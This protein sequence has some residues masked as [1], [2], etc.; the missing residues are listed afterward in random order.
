MYSEIL[1]WDLSKYNG[2]ADGSTDVDF[3]IGIAQGVQA[4]FYRGTIGTS[5]IDYKFYT[6][7]QKSMAR[8]LPFAPYHAFRPEA[9]GRAQGYA[10]AQLVMS[11]VGLTR[12]GNLSPVFDI[13]VDGGLPVAELSSKCQKMIEGYRAA[14][15][16]L[17]NGIQIEPMIYTS[18]GWWNDHM[19]KSAWASVYR[20]WVAQWPYSGRCTVQQ[21]NAMYPNL[22]PTVPVT[23]IS[24][25]E[26]MWQFSANGN[27]QGR[28][29]GATGSVNMDLTWF[30]GDREKFKTI[31]GVYPGAVAPPQPPPA[32]QTWIVDPNK[33]R[34]VNF[35][36]QPRV[37]TATMRGALVANEPVNPVKEQNGWTQVEIVNRYW[38]SSQYLK[39]I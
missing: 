13:E 25:R 2:A 35:R 31:F 34:A 33:A 24:P 26:I 15:L 38:I 4:G 21:W 6:Y 10:F 37:A 27:E 20:L 28:T 9:D 18:P 7:A 36:S 5:G 32:T 16:D 29:F 1:I 22:K 3:D 17:N 8:G 39:K 12:M 11:G 14:I 30:N 19:G 23:W